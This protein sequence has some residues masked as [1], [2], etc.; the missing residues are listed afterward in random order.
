[1]IKLFLSEVRRLFF[2]PLTHHF[3]ETTTTNKLTANGYIRV[4]VS[5]SISSSP[6]STSPESRRI[7]TIFFASL[8]GLKSDT[9]ILYENLLKSSQKSINDVYRLDDLHV[10]GRGRYS[11][12]YE[13]PSSMT[14]T[15]LKHLKVSS[16]TVENSSEQ[17]DYPDRAIKL[18]QKKEYAASVANHEERPCT[19]LR[20]IVLLW[21]GNYKGISGDEEEVDKPFCKIYGVLETRSVLRF[22]LN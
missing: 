6:T 12:I 8:S 15:N 7:T 18:V 3:L 10:V 9:E 16:S 1:M 13:S 2:P 22:L 17:N 14:P 5:K 4:L 11:E 21:R 19:L 20:E